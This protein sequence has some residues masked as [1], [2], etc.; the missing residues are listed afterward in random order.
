M[1]ELSNDVSS[2]NRRDLYSRIRAWLET[3]ATS[4]RSK[5]D[6]SP[7]PP[8]VLRLAR[9]LP[10]PDSATESDLDV[11]FTEVL[12]GNLEYFYT[13][14]DAYGV[15]LHEYARQGLSIYPKGLMDEE[16]ERSI[17]TSVLYPLTLSHESEEQQRAHRV[18]HNR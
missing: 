3:N 11:A 13:E 9:A 15:G 17:R 6:Q 5:R 16:C 14:R 1:P 2:I 4:W 10:S 18:L 8:N 7:V 12:R